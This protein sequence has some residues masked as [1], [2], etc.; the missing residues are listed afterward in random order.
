MIEP[1]PTTVHSLLYVHIRIR[2][3]RTT[4]RPNWNNYYILYT[5]VKWN[6]LS[7]SHY[8]L[9]L[10]T[11]TTNCDIS[12]GMQGSLV[13]RRVYIGRNYGSIAKDLKLDWTI[14]V[15]WKRRV[16]VN[17]VCLSKWFSFELIRWYSNKKADKYS[18]CYLFLPLSEHVVYFYEADYYCIILSHYLH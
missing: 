3:F 7:G 11:N 2:T 8:F 16:T 14:Q 5:W 10:F 15:T 1:L 6:E 12:L 17:Q 4:V 18:S 13:P 9:H